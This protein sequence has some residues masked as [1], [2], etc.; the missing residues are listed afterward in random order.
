[1][2]VTQDVEGSQRDKNESLSLRVRACV[3]E[4]VRECVCACYPVERIRI[5]LRQYFP[6]KIW[7][8]KEIV[9]KNN[10]AEKGGG[11]KWTPFLD[12]GF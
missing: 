6:V 7:E 11:G 5:S 4:C 10:I 2:S 1:M 3:R 9:R 8:R 12:I